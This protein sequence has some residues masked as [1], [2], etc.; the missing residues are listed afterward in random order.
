M[1]HRWPTAGH[2]HPYASDGIHTDRAGSSRSARDPKGSNTLNEL[3]QVANKAYKASTLPTK[4]AHYIVLYPHTGGKYN[5]IEPN[6]SLAKQVPSAWR[7]Y[8]LLPPSNHLSAGHTAPNPQYRLAP[9]KGEQIAVTETTQSGPAREPRAVAS[10]GECRVGG[11][12]VDGK[13]R[14]TV[15]WTWMKPIRRK[16]RLLTDQKGV[17]SASLEYK[18]SPNVQPLIVFSERKHIPKKGYRLSTDWLAINHSKFQ[19]SGSPLASRRTRDKQHSHHV[20]RIRTTRPAQR[21]APVP[22]P[23]WSSAIILYSAT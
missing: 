2:P 23:Q 21:I 20:Q 10:A 18:S 9:R 17:R 19:R 8:G 1:L 5:I 16:Y 6:I 14:S 22:M 15:G 4:S 12:A 3:C 13:D 11:Q 7:Q